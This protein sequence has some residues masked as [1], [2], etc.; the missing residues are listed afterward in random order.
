MDPSGEDIPR[1]F[2]G[3]SLAECLAEAQAAAKAAEE[4]R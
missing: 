1:R 2:T 3:D 4:K